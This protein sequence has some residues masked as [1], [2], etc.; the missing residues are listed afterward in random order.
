ML[1]AAACDAGEWWPERIGK[2]QTTGD[3]ISERDLAERAWDHTTFLAKARG[4]TRAV[5][6]RALKRNH[7][8]LEGA[9]RTEPGSSRFPRQNGH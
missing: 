9:A 1:N 4:L 6:N 2:A 3:I 7:S 8:Q 5:A